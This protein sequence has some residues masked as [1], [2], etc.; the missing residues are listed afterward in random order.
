MDDSNAVRSRRPQGHRRQRATKCLYA[1]QAADAS[2]WKCVEKS[3]LRTSNDDDKNY[4]KKY[5]LEAKK[6]SNKSTINRFATAAKPLAPKAIVKNTF[7]Q[8]RDLAKASYHLGTPISKLEKNILQEMVFRSL[9][10]NISTSSS[11]EEANERPS[12]SAG[13]ERAGCSY[14]EQ[15]S[16]VPEA[17]AFQRYAQAPLRPL[18]PPKGTSMEK[19]HNSEQYGRDFTTYDGITARNRRQSASVPCRR[20]DSP[21]HA[22]ERVHKIRHKLNPVRDY[23]LMD[24]VHYLAQGEFA[25]RDDGIKLTPSREAVL[26]D[27][28]WEDVCRTHWPNAR[29]NRRIASHPERTCSS[30]RG[31]GE[32][33]RLIDNLLRERI[34]HVERRRRRHY[35]IVKLNNRHENSKPLGKTGDI[36]VASHKKK[37]RDLA[38]SDHRAAS[39]LSERRWVEQTSTRRS[40][41][42]HDILTNDKPRHTVRSDECAPG[43]S[44]AVNRVTENRE[45]NTVCNRAECERANQSHNVMRCS[46]RE[47]ASGSSASNSSNRNSKPARLVIRKDVARRK[48]QIEELNLEHYILLPTLVV[49]T[50]SNM[51]RQKKFNE[52]YHRILHV[53]FRNKCDG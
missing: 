48:H 47:A 32:L 22:A 9:D 11:D 8:S 6:N 33:Q 41:K 23:R 14:I 52:L 17:S 35:R 45:E 18:S 39:V 19:E 10:E 50:P 42:S 5:Y 34:A 4:S 15:Y 2:I 31:S 13:S 40:Y 36:I 46:D 20:E 25:P 43:P 28:I 7:T 26:S 49:R 1:C 38:S 24:T 53:H 12:K 51:R 30:R 44:Y 37:D 27:I 3:N 21:K 29:L 16:H